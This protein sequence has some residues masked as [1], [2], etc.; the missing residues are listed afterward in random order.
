VLEVTLPS[1]S[2]ATVAAR[3]LIKPER[4]SCCAKKTDLRDRRNALQRS[5]EDQ[6]KSAVL[7][8]SNEY[9]C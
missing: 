8:A 7:S 2:F 9:P 1:G 3:E 4:G 6:D 5:A